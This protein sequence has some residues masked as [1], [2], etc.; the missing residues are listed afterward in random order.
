MARARK[1]DRPLPRQVTPRYRRGLGR[2]RAGAA[3]VPL[4][5]ASPVKESRV[6]SR[7]AT[8]RH[9]PRQAVVDARALALPPAFVGVARRPSSRPRSGSPWGRSLAC[10]SSGPGCRLGGHD[11]SRPAY[12]LYVGLD[13]TAEGRRAQSSRRALVRRLGGRNC[14]AR[15]DRRRVEPR[16]AAFRSVGLRRLRKLPGEAPA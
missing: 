14:S 3:Y 10:S 4:D 1:S 11:P 16:A 6:S 5:V 15:S 9:L 8:L 13:R 12:I 7:T 2:A